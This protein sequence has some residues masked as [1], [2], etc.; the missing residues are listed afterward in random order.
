M[1]NSILFFCFVFGAICFAQDIT[2]TLPPGG[3]FIVKMPQL[4]F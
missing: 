2:N 4:I 1:K 3:K